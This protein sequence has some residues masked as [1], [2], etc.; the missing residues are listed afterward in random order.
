MPLC[1]IPPT[2][3]SVDLQRTLPTLAAAVLRVFAAAADPLV[4]LSNGAT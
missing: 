2:Q 1:S 3:S 4:P